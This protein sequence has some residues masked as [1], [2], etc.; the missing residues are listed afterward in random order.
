MKQ[1]I[2]CSLLLCVSLL[3]AD[4]Q[5]H[6]LVDALVKH[7]QT[8]K[9]L[10][11]AV[12]EAMPEQDYTFK[13]TPS[14]MSFGEQMNHIAKGN[15]NYCAAASG[16]TNPLTGSL[17]NSK[18]SAEKNLTTAYDFCISGLEKM[19][20][21]DVTKMKGS[22]TRQASAFELFWGGFTHA[23]HHRGQAEV[24]LRLKGI[25]PPEYKF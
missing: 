9:A 14:E 5:E 7:W 17:D 6:A 23:A 21:G 12:A 1:M 4:A 18:A 2:R 25:K 11:L 16:A 3:I 24:Y 13:A 20:D 8:S 19:S 10:T 22:G 15:T